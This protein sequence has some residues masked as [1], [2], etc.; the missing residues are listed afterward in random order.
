MK[1]KVEIKKTMT[2]DEVLK[3]N[4]NH[5]QTLL[6]FGMHCFGCPMSRSETLEEAAEVHG[7][8]VEDLLTKLNEK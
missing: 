7:F 8:K 4:P 6:S 5:A 1:K 2:I 3:L